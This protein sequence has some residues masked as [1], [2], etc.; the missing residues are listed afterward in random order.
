[1]CTSLQRVLILFEDPI[2]STNIH[3]A[4]PFFN[5]DIAITHPYRIPEEGF[6]LH[7]RGKPAWDLPNMPSP[8][9]RASLIAEESDRLVAL[10]EQLTVPYTPPRPAG[11]DGTWHILE[12]ATGAHSMR[13][14]WWVELPPGWE[15]A[16][17]LYDYALTIARRTYLESLE[18]RGG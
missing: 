18:H 12:I 15:S 9:W 7:G 10:L 11:F 2:V 3:S 13:L 4:P 6:L 1:M 14:E 17:A 16:G 8:E 5:A